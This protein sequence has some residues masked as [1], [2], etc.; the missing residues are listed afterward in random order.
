[1]KN[2]ILDQ[3]QIAQSPKNV[4]C[5]SCSR[6]QKYDLSLP[7]YIFFLFY[8]YVHTYTTVG[9][10]CSHCILIHQYYGSQSNDSTYLARS[11]EIC[12]VVFT[13]PFTS[14]LYSQ[15]QE[16]QELPTSP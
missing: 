11:W 7:V 8:K 2:V 15:L 6:L 14:R 9:P 10:D 1:M 5:R 13:S 16:L 3:D 12:A 4:I